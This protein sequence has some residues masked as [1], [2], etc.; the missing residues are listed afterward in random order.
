ML[1]RAGTTDR[2]LR[3]THAYRRSLIIIL[4]PAHTSTGTQRVIVESALPVSLGRAQTPPALRACDTVE[5][6]SSLV[7][8][9]AK[10]F[11]LLG[12]TI[13]SAGVLHERVVSFSEE[14]QTHKFRAFNA[15]AGAGAMS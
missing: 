15:F 8:N 13:A 12:I 1:D 5:F 3:L 11:G 14:G 9:F 7:I 2:Y 10:D 6:K 4:T